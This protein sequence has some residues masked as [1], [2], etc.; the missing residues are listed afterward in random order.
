MVEEDG[1]VKLWKNKL[2]GIKKM[3][4]IVSFCMIN[5]TEIEVY[6]GV[7]MIRCRAPPDYRL[8]F[9]TINYTYA[10]KNE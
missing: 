7:Y 2:R 10:C 6:R 9:V 3:R 5:N 4:K 8:D 1:N